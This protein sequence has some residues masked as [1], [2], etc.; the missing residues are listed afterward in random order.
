M[1]WIQ[2]VLDSTKTRLSP[3]YMSMLTSVLALLPLVVFAGEGS[4][5]YRGLGS[6]LI[7]G[8][9]FASIVSVFI[10]PAMLLSIKPHRN[11]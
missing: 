4:E 7:G 1:P 8:L 9:M 5:I 3:I 11:S 10:I 6:V 2:S